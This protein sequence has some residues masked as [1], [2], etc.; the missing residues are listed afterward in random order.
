MWSPSLA[1]VWQCPARRGQLWAESLWRLPG[2]SCCPGLQRAAG[3]PANP[4]APQASQLGVYKAFVDN[5]KIAL[6]TAEKCSQSNY[7]FQKIS[8]VSWAGAVPGAQGRER[9]PR[10]WA[11]CIHPTE[12]IPLSWGLSGTVAGQGHQWL[13]WR[14]VVSAH[15][16]GLSPAS[17]KLS[18]HSSFLGSQGSLNLLAP[19]GECE[20]GVLGTCSSSRL[21]LSPCPAPL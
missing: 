21:P 7:Q 10:G 14:V 2:P 11:S 15:C 20:R 17:C 8:E 13:C 9:H 4:C 16:K 19:S 6:E 18:P 1:V 3:C 5:Y 12:T